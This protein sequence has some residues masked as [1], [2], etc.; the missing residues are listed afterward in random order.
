MYSDASLAQTAEGLLVEEQEY[1]TVA[2]QN[3]DL[4][5]V[6]VSDYKI[7]LD[8]LISS[9]AVHESTMKQA[10][11]LVKFL[12]THLAEKQDMV[13]SLNVSTKELMKNVTELRKKVSNGENSLM[14]VLEAHTD[15]FLKI[16][17]VHEEKEQLEQQWEVQKKIV[18]EA[19]V[20]ENGLGFFEKYRKRRQ[21][22]S[23]K[24]ELDNLVSRIKTKQ[25][26]EWELNE[27]LNRLKVTRMNLDK[28]VQNNRLLIT[29]TENHILDN[30]V[31]LKTHQTE[32][33]RVSAELHEAEKRCFIEK[34]KVKNLRIKIK[35][36]R[37]ETASCSE[38]LERLGRVL[39]KR[40]AQVVDIRKRQEEFS[41]KVTLDIEED[42]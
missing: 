34:D 8:G 12:N 21:A 25:T 18:D 20:E 4:M 7:Q 22:S 33:E 1:V 2:E 19:R 5:R 6:K 3:L 41:D 32:V 39:T 26:A 35:Q 30:G 37:N 31:M 10:E 36:K 28:D 42:S 14:K 11:A 16:E 27:E 23:L 13:M 15:A 38:A 9:L 29:T 40:Q 17:N 24:G